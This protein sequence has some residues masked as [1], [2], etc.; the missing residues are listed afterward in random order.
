MQAPPQA[1]RAQGRPCGERALP[2][3]WVGG[4]GG[5]GGGAAGTGAGHKP[6][7]YGYE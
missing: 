4:L 2:R 7:G 5:Q 6:S 1:P 3:M